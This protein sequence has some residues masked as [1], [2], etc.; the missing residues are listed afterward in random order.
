M[1]DVGTTNGAN[2]DR[3]VEKALTSLPAGIRLLDAGA[4]TQPYRKFCAHLEYVSQDFG[5]YDPDEGDAGLQAADFIYGELDHICD[6]TD[7]PEPDGAFDAVLCTEVLEHLPNP[8]AA[9]V[10]LSRLLKKGGTMILT[11]PFSS[12]THFAPYH[13]CTGFNRFFYEKHLPELGLEIQE[14]TPNGGY[15]GH[16][17]QEVRRVPAMGEQFSGLKIPRKI[18]RAHRR[19]LKWM[20][21]L[22]NADRGSSA[23][24]SYGLHVIAKKVVSSA[25][26]SVAA[27]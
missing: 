11:A 25:V 18:K 21:E 2:R 3:W 1:I 12:L 6:I 15:F 27:D 22:E 7:I 13:Y 9:L 26:S 24:L 10:E 20:Q 19:F 8:V 4:G 23:M 16:I 5:Q 14:I 17:A